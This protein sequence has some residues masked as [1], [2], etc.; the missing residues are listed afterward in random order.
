MAS[1]CNKLYNA[2]ECCFELL[3]IA[4]LINSRVRSLS[5]PTPCVVRTL[6]DADLLA[7]DSVQVLVIHG[8]LSRHPNVKIE[9][10]ESIRVRPRAPAFLLQTVSLFVCL[11]PERFPM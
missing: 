7:V 3:P 4:T 6:R 8:G 11:R 2:F 5:C 9:H 1:Y 10:I